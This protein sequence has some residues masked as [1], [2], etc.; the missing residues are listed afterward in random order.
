MQ[1]YLIG[2]DSKAAKI[3]LKYRLR[4]A[5]YS[6]NFK[7]AELVKMCPLCQSHED[8]QCLA[9]SCP[10]IREKIKVDEPYEYL[11]AS[12]IPVNLVKILESI[13]KIRQNCN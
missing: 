3:V 9:F 6:E 7:G 1:S 10:S 2:L 11:F 4:M 12:E 8:F 5:N 13:E